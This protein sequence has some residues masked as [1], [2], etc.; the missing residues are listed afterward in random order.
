M[1][2]AHL[3]DPRRVAGGRG[4]RAAG[5]A[6]DRLKD[7]GR[8]LFR[9]EPQYFRLELRH[10]VGAYA[11]AGNPGGR[12]IFVHRRQEGCLQ[13][14][15]FKWSAPREE[16]GDGQRPQAYCHARSGGVR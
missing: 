14:R 15:T 4:H 3:A 7:K 9:A 11:V 1:P 6:D 2:I 16:V 8:Y 13:Q 12:P 10:T 5:G